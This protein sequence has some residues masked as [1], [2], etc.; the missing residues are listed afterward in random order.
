MP[1]PAAAV[2]DQGEGARFHAAPL[3]LL[4]ST[5]RGR[6]SMPPRCCRYVRRRGGEVQ[7]RPAAAVV[8]TKR[9]GEVPCRPAAAVVFVGEG[10]V[11]FRPQLQHRRVVPDA[12]GEMCA[13]LAAEIVLTL[14]DVIT[15]CWEMLFSGMGL[16]G[17]TG[18]R[19]RDRQQQR[20]SVRNELLGN[21]LLPD[22]ETNKHKHKHKCKSKERVINVIYMV[23]CF[24]IFF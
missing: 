1:C 17:Q 18:R 9:G 13:V 21:A 3:L 4:R 24:A 14:Q 2:V 6:G 16:A 23:K 8:S 12:K 20:I 19:R 15:G 10:K 11:V 7:C 5:E 22:E